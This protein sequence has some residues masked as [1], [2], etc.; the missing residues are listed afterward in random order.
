MKSNL[1]FPDYERCL[2]N[3][4]N[5]IMKKFGVEP[6]GK[7]HPLIDE[8]LKKD[9]KNVVLFLLDGMG[10]KIIENHLAEDGAF[11]SHLAGECTTVFL[12]TT[13]AAT[14]S[15]ASGLQPC[16]HSWLGW[17]CYYPQIDKNVTV[18]LNIVQGSD[19]VPAADYPVASTFTPYV[20]VVDRMKEAGK[21]AYASTPYITPN[22]KTFEAVC[23]RVKELCESDGQKYIYAYWENPDALLHD[24][25]CNSAEVR[26]NLLYMEKY[27]ADMVEDME[28][29]LLIITAD[30]GHKD[31]N[32]VYLHEYPEL[33][34]CLI[35]P[36]SL[37]TRVLNLFVKEEKK[38]FFEEEFNR[39]FGEKYLLM[40]MEEVLERNLM[41]DG[42][43]H[44]NFR[45]MLG[46]YLAIATDDLQIVPLPIE[47]DMVSMH[48]SLTEDEMIIPLIIFEK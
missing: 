41:G 42:K 19:D 5:S 44:E 39:I 20:S 11:R 17:D 15:A 12:S 26:D 24:Y 47:T 1:V 37:E 30:H 8:Y 36:A 10:K 16:E 34:E 43:W 3:I 48:G 31:V 25:G 13:V 22:P 2:A 40:T 29:T 18:F 7:T 46:N 45:G 27:I 33:C 35:R 38:E 21:N 32:T 6:V 14:T 23:Q 28:D 9:Y 4:P